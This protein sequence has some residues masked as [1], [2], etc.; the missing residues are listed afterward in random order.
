[1]PPTW[2]TLDK[3]IDAKKAKEGDQVIAKTIQDIKAGNGQVIRRNSNI[4]VIHQENV[5]FRRSSE[6]NQAADFSIRAQIF[7]A[8][9]QPDRTPRK[10]SLQSFNQ[11][12]CRIIRITDPEQNFITR[13][14]LHEMRA[15]ALIHFGI[16][17]LERLQNR[18]RRQ[19]C[20]FNRRKIRRISPRRPYAQGAIAHTRHSNRGSDC[21]RYVQT[22]FVQEVSQKDKAPGPDCPQQYACAADTSKNTTPTLSRDLG[23]L[24]KI[25][26]ATK[27]IDD[28]SARGRTRE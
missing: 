18:D 11:R 5:E 3:T 22:N 12:R 27:L 28:P 14:I 26:H 23:S 20:N 1:M 19:I 6:L 2:A 16:G 21:G 13:I 25:F 4:A 9:D 10:L 17:S 15:K 8:Q 24:R 7:L